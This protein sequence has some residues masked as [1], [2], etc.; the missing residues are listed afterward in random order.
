MKV[1]RD[2]KD[3]TAKE[4]LFLSIGFFDG[5]HLGHTRLIKKLIAESRKAKSKSAVLTFVH[6]PLS[7]V[8]PPH[9]PE[10]ITTREE[11]LEALEELG[12]DY[13]FLL[14][15][16]GELAST[17]AEKFVEN[18]LVNY[19]KVRK[20]LVGS[21]FRFG[22]GRRGDVEFLRGKG[23]QFHF[24]VEAVPLTRVGGE[25]VSSSRLRQLIKMG[26]LAKTKRFL[27]RD[28]SVRGT[29]VKGKGISRHIQYP[30][31]NLMLREKVLPPEGVYSGWA[32]VGERVY[33]VAFDLRKDGQSIIE[34]HLLDSNEDLYGKEVEIVFRQKIRERLAFSSREKAQRQIEKDVAVARKLLAGAK[35]KMITEDR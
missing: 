29:V 19:L 30:T 24:K 9:A 23:E 14:T 10:L 16:E 11:K 7:V 18:I 31:A 12:V 34:A 17:P 8:A 25:V 28:F 6:H 3:Y 1:F 26:D 4:E 22:K 15:F 21:N 27:G 2:F 33:L 35:P 5:L 32:R 13:V 20:I